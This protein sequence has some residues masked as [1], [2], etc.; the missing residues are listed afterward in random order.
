MAFCMNCSSLGLA[1]RS[2]SSLHCIT[3]NVRVREKYQIK[4]HYFYS[5]QDFW[6]FAI[7]ICWQW[8]W[9]HV[10][11]R[12]C[13]ASGL[14][15]NIPGAHVVYSAFVE[16]LIFRVNHEPHSLLRLLLFILCAHCQQFCCS[17][18]SGLV[19]HDLEAWAPR[20]LA[21]R[22][23]NVVVVVEPTSIY[24]STY[25][26]FASISFLDIFGEPYSILVVTCKPDQ[27][28]ACAHG[29]GH[30][31]VSYCREASNLKRV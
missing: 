15:W 11:T 25:V 3:R 16:Q 28:L 26:C 4:T 22:T 21:K 31:D 10:Y 6:L 9:K 5:L 24:W 18:S 30:C 19:S 17:Q 7:T 1:Y 2:S 27:R 14:H 12:N 20:E 23:L 13:T 8:S 29:P